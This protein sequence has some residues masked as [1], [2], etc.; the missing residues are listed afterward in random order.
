M[1]SNKVYYQELKCFEKANEKVKKSAYQKQYID[2][3]SLPTEQMQLEMRE[4]LLKYGETVS[5]ETVRLMESSIKYI[6]QFIS[7]QRLRRIKSFRDKDMEKWIKLLKGWMMQNGNATTIPRVSRYG[8]MSTGTNKHILFFRRFLNFIQPKQEVE[9]EWEKDIWELDKLDIEIVGNPI[10]N[11]QTIR[12]VKITQPEMRSE[13]K[14]VIR[15]HLMECKLGTVQREMTVARDFSKYLK[16]KHPRIQSYKKVTRIILEAYI[17]DRMTSEKQYRGNSDH[18]HKLQS[19]LETVGKLD[20]CKELENLFL[21]TDI[22][23]EL[24]PEFKFYTD[25]ELIRFNAQLIKM[26]E[27]LARCLVLHQM[28]GTRISDTLTLETDCLYKQDE[29]YMVTIHQVKTSSYAKP[30]S[31]EVAQLIQNSIEYT[32]NR[33]GKT[34][35][36]FVNEKDPSRPLQY[37]TIKHKIQTMITKE[38]LKDDNGERFQFGTHMF[39]HFYGVKLTEMHLDDWSIAR[40]LGHKKLGSVSHYRRMSNVVMAD[41][42]RKIR[43]MMSDIMEANVE[44]WEDEYEQIRQNARREQKEK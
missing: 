31:K 37:I 33:Y 27:Q 16:E 32:E 19:I 20:D 43:K 1:E 2:L 22:P 41:E 35:Y 38:E 29:Q 6:L 39:R 28:L 40:L 42:T 11:V 13:L 9:S 14:R 7:E 10:Y 5:L 25:S 8:T 36:I 4:Y 23:Q 12:F 44:G 18:I 21:N 26:D 15:Q 34:K 30:I 24:D 17:T 3:S